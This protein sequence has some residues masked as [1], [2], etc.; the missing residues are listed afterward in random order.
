VVH[1]LAAVLCQGALQ[2]LQKDLRL[3]FG[4]L[5]LWLRNGVRHRF[6]LH[7]FELEETCVVGLHWEDQ[8]GLGCSILSQSI[9]LTRES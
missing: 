8:S 1:G 3:V 5:E 6:R 2:V 7:R 9:D 4:V